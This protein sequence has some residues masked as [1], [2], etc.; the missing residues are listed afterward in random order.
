MTVNGLDRVF[1][2]PYVNWNNMHTHPSNLKDQGLHKVGMKIENIEIG[3]Y[4]IRVS[5]N[6][7]CEENI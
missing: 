4:G 7:G 5:N 1:P 3:G 6:S 2:I